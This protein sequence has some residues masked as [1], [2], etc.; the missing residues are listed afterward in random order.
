MSLPQWIA[1]AAACLGLVV[2]TL[3]V[4]GVVWKASAKFTKLEYSDEIK[5]K[6]LEAIE[7]QMVE[8]TVKTEK[9]LAALD[10]KT[11]AH[12]QMITRLSTMMDEWQRHRPSAA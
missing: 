8:N 3:V 2:N 6:R 11:N 10:L 7:R 12:A 9:E 4:V 1:M 5:Q